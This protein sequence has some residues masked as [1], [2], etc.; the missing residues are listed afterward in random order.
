MILFLSQTTRIL[1]DKLESPQLINITCDVLSFRHGSVIGDLLVAIEATSQASADSLGDKADELK[2]ENGT[3]LYS[4]ESIYVKEFASDRKYTNECFTRLRFCC[5]CLFV[6][7]FIVNTK[8]NRNRR[9]R[10]L[11]L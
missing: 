10:S 5:T 11:S 6:N 7:Q 2:P 9:Y 3:Y 1:M 8:K 4:N